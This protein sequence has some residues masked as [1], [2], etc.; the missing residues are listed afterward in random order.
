MGIGDW[1]LGIGD[2]GLG[3]GHKEDK[4]ISPLKQIISATQKESNNIFKKINKNSK[5]QILFLT[6]NSKKNLNEL[7]A[8]GKLKLKASEEKRKNNF[9]SHS[10]IIVKKPKNTSPI[11]STKHHNKNKISIELNYNSLNKPK[12][13]D[14]DREN[15]E[16][17]L[18]RNNIRN[19]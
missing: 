18:N 3:I 15:K 4:N 9:T 16:N 11:F 7:D 8:E 6:N 10:T 1:G 14:K 5:S 12:D 17:S 13:I 2:W 19:R